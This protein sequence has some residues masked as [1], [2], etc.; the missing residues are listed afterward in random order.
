MRMEPNDP[1]QDGFALSDLL[2]MAIL[3][4]NEIETLCAK[5]ARGAGLSWGHAEEAG[6]AAGWLHAHGIDGASALCA[7]LERTAGRPWAEICPRV[8]AGRWLAGGNTPICPIALGAALSDFCE[9]PEGALGKGLSAGP[10]SHPVLVVPFIARIAL[11]LER[12]VLM[13]FDGGEV[14][15][16]DAWITGDVERL[17]DLVEGFL[18]LSMAADV[19]EERRA[20]GYACPGA[21]LAALGDLALNTTVPPSERSRADAGAGTTDND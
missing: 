5:A 16:G 7:H 10:V 4:R 14:A 12:P 11:V 9:L 3:S 20:P 21:V 2:P 19:A 17:A 15:I 6:F 13:R 18:N 1:T 8:E